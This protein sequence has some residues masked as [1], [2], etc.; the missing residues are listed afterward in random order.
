MRFEGH[1]LARILHEGSGICSVAGKA[2]W[3]FPHIHVLHDTGTP[4]QW[5]I[6]CRVIAI[7]MAQGGSFKMHRQMRSDLE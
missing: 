5:T 7:A 6:A 3:S 1:G 2:G 4:V